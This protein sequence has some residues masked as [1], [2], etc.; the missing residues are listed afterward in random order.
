MVLPGNQHP[1]G[2]D[3]HNCLVGAVMSVRQRFQIGPAGQPEQF[4]PEHVS[5]NRYC[6]DQLADRFDL[7]EQKGRIARSAG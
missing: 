6:A 5:I 2:P 3:I 1:V 4:A 7:T